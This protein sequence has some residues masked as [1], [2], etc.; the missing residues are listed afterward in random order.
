M[1]T[2]FAIGAHPD[3]I[4]FLM[5]GTLFLLKQLGYGIHYMNVGNGSCGTNELSKKEIVRLR[6]SESMA[7]AEY[8]GATFHEGICDDLAIFYDQPT[9][10]KLGSIIR[11]VDPDILL[12]HSPVDYMEDHTNVCRLAV[13]AAFARGMPNFPVDPPRDA[14]SGTI[15]VYHAQPYSH[16][17]PLRRLV[18]PEMMVDVTSVINQKREMLGFHHSQKKWLDE[19][20]GHD[21]YLN[22]LR[23]FDARCGQLSGKFK[24]AEGWRRHLH[25]GFGREND[26][27][28]RDALGDRILLIGSQRIDHDSIT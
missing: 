9:L 27:P 21:S 2:V 13:T 22:A 3:D 15:T 5:S 4:E 14:I 1:P 16:Y 12:T 7:A 11:D 26:D 10:A 24:F 18:Q 17:D 8:L 25:L 19:S 6:R 28:L 23:D 20:Q